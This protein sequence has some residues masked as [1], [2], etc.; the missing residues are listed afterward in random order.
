M[1]LDTFASGAWG[2]KMFFGMFF[3]HP[4]LRVR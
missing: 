4:V 2:R 3:A 1:V